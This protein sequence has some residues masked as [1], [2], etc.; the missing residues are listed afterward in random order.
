MANLKKLEKITQKLKCEISALGKLKELME[1]EFRFILITDL[2]SANR[3][4]GFLNAL[5]S[6]QGE[7]ATFVKEYPLFF[8]LK[9]AT[10]NMQLP[11]DLKS[12]GVTLTLRLLNEAMSPLANRLP[13]DPSNPLSNVNIF[14]ELNSLT[15]RVQSAGSS[16]P[17]SL[18]T[19]SE[20]ISSFRFVE[21][22]IFSIYHAHW[23]VISYADFQNEIFVSPLEEFLITSY[24]ADNGL[25]L[26]PAMRDRFVSIAGR[27]LERRALFV[28]VSDTSE[29]FLTLP[30]SKQ[31][32]GELLTVAGHNDRDPESQKL[33]PVLSFDDSVLTSIPPEKT[34]FYDYILEALRKGEAFTSSVETVNLFLQN[35]ITFIISEMGEFLRLI[36]SRTAKTKPPLDFLTLFQ[37][38]TEIRDKL[39]HW[40]LT[41]KTCAMYRTI[42]LLN[43]TPLKVQWENYNEFFQLVD[44]VSL[45]GAMFY[46]LL[47]DCSPTS[48]SRNHILKKRK[49]AL[50][51]FSD[52]NNTLW[53][54]PPRSHEA[55]L[56]RALTGIIRLFAIK[57]PEECLNKITNAIPTHIARITH[58]AIVRKQWGFRVVVSEEGRGELAG[59]EALGG[60]GGGPRED[61]L[62]PNNREV[63]SYCQNLQLGNMAYDKR[64]VSNVHFHKAF[65]KTQ[66]CPILQNIF[67]NRVQKNRALFQLR[68]LATFATAHNTSLDPFR[69]ALTDFYLSVKDIFD[70]NSENVIFTDIL[71]SFELIVHELKPCTADF[72]FPTLL[73]EELFHRQYRTASFTLLD[74]IS[75]FLK[76]CDPILEGIVHTIKLGG[77]LCHSH[78]N[79][80]LGSANIKL[81]T[82]RDTLEFQ[83]QEL[84]TLISNLEK[85]IREALTVLIQ[86]TSDVHQSYV[87]LLEI[88]AQLDGLKAHRIKFNLINPNFNHIHKIF[89]ILF[90]KFRMI[91]DIIKSSCT[92][93]LTQHFSVLF[94]PGLIEIDTIKTIINFTGNIEDT[95]IFMQSLGQPIQEKVEIGTNG[96][97]AAHHQIQLDEDDVEQIKELIT[98]TGPSQGVIK[99][100]YSASLNNN[101]HPLKIDWDDFNNS[102]YLSEDSSLK[103][104]I[105]SFSEILNSI[106]Q[107]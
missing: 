13:G 11:L 93:S 66:A 58:A 9:S 84:K 7:Y 3:V 34:F 107:G 28:P 96:P 97:A 50:A 57:V 48:I 33:W 4:H 25:A 94:Q 71:D 60:G 106:F 40:G 54:Q 47:S 26:T 56:T 43:A 65:L 95:E 22:I 69:T 74:S 52:N 91:V 32:T 104:K 98:L 44:Q 35:G 77:K 24:L 87:V 55:P 5:F 63:E 75:R 36:L 79:Y 80:E 14:S 31:R 105:L 61:H 42:L 8:L 19:F 53:Q 37:T 90:E 81:Q 103:F 62:P 29:T 49:Y 88:L 6:D 46:N 12:E 76:D 17:S 59:Y 82:K 1:I 45:F 86:M 30:I 70:S 10:F 2:T 27:V 68:W 100:N 18:P 83:V 39:F 99:R 89:M 67:S 38:V 21:E 41:Q 101:R 16:D 20:I 51:Q 102:V 64:Y 15:Q 23:N 73:L 78:F 72:E 92:Y 85:T